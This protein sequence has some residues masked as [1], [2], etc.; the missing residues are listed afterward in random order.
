MK[1]FEVRSSLIFFIIIV[2]VLLHSIDHLD[3]FEAFKYICSALVLLLLALVFLWACLTLLLGLL[4]DFFELSIFLLVSSLVV[5]LILLCCLFCVNS[6]TKF[7]LFILFEEFI[8]EEVQVKHGILFVANT[9][10]G[11]PVAIFHLKP[12][13]T[14]VL[15]LLF[16]LLQVLFS[17][18]L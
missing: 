12:K 5:F 17:H 14:H 9:E 11:F 4:D 1:T 16:I 7:D 8:I 13:L 15:D 2:F 18:F 10:Y 6:E 3:F